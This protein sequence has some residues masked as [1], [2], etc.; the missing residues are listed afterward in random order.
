MEQVTPHSLAITDGK[1]IFWT[2][3]DDLILFLSRGSLATL[4]I[5]STVVFFLRVRK[6]PMWQMVPWYVRAF[7]FVWTAVLWMFVCFIFFTGIFPA[8][9]EWFRAM[10]GYAFFGT[11]WGWSWCIWYLT[12]SDVPAQIIN[13]Y[14]ESVARELQ[15]RVTP[16]KETE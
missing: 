7:T 1:Y 12:R 5:V 4:A 16:R 6:T 13:Q 9:A 15:E 10:Y 11:L 8:Q 3:L 2:D 14:N